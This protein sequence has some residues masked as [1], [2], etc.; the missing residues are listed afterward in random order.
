M[1]KPGDIVK[2]NNSGQVGRVIKQRHHR[3][4][5]PV[6]YWASGTK[7]GRFVASGRRVRLWF[8]KNVEVLA[9]H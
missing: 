1:M 2:N 7:R 4:Y 3:D 5:V 6:E 8:K 9:A